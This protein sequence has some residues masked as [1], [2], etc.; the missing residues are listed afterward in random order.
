MYIV[1]V[2]KQNLVNYAVGQAGMSVHLPPYKVCM[3]S[4]YKLLITELSKL[5]QTVTFPT[6]LL[7]TSSWNLGLGTYD[8]CGFPREN[9]G[10]TPKPIPQ[11]LPSMWFH[12]HP[13][14]S[15]KIIGYSVVSI[16]CYHHYLKLH[17]IL[18]VVNMW[19]NIHSM[20]ING[21]K[22]FSTSQTLSSW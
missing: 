15:S 2:N 21:A 12:N 13:S 1:P 9:V 22:H 6:Y 19:Q 14:N 20:G 16:T 7:H 11:W 8:C 18:T 10:I 4:M 5:A 17:K 3:C